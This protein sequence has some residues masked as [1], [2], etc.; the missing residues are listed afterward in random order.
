[1]RARLDCG[2]KMAKRSDF[3][4]MPPNLFLIPPLLPSQLMLFFFARFAK[5]ALVLPLRRRKK[6][7]KCLIAMW[8]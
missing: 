3:S 1:M 7:G 2:K 5:V 4:L 8:R 6:G